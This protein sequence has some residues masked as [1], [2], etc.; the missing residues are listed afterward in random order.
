MNAYKSG[1]SRKAKSEAAATGAAAGFGAGLGA[2]VGA[3]LG[4]G[5]GAVAEGVGAA[6]GGVGKGV[7]AT[8]AGFGKGLGAVYGAILGEMAKFYKKIMKF[9]LWGLVAF[10]VIGIPIYTCREK[11]SVSK[12]EKNMQAAEYVVNGSSVVMSGKL[13]DYFS[14][15]EDVVVTQKEGA[16]EAEISLTLLCKKPLS[17]IQPFYK[18]ELTIGEGVV[19]SPEKSVL[20]TALLSMKKTTPS[21]MDTDMQICK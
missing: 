10:L 5:V 7:G 18:P 9:F 14:V 8:V 11:S 19:I 4:K 16:F 17:E 13:G 20:G 2:A 21:L 1:S 3:G 6:V 12:Q 15:P